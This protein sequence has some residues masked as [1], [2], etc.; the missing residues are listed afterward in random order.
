MKAFVLF[1]AVLLF[2]VA[3]HAETAQP[4]NLTS[5]EI[6]ALVK[7]QAL[8]TK[9]T[10]WGEVRLD[11]DA[12]GSLSGDNKGSSDRG[13]WRVEDGKLCLSWFRWD[14]AG[15]GIVRKIGND[16]QHLWPDGKVHFVYSP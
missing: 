8:F 7:D 2:S 4:V 12:D 6:I 13:T 11:F 5:A 15:C 10:R 16:F 3:A 9:N 14:Y 1:I